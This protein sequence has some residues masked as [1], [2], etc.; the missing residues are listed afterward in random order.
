MNYYQHHIGDFIKA[1]SRLTDG[2]AMG[3][4]RL[5]WKYYDEET[6]IVDDVKLLSFQMGSSEND[7]SLILKSFFVLENG[8]W[9]HT[10][11]DKEIAEYHGFCTKQRENG[12]KGGRPKGKNKPAG[13]PEETQSKPNGNPT[14]TLTTTHYPLTNIKNKIITP[15]G[16]SDS[17]FQ[18]FVTLR[19]GLKAPVT[20]TALKALEREASKANL[21]LQEVMEL[22]CKNGW[23]GFSAEWIKEKPKESAAY[24]RK[25]KMLSGLTGGI[26]GSTEDAQFKPIT[27]T[28]DMEAS[29]ARLPG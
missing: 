25:M 2:Q 15:D 24:S 18:D 17:V 1:T 4:L 16:V 14:E 12:K 29:H 26:H 23:R 22:C 21:S 13:N 7:L 19:K 5:L 8:Q 27:E 10:R 9:H 28:I 3:Y 20:A 6:P 11:C